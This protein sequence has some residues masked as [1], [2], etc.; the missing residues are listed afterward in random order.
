MKAIQ[1]NEISS[2]KPTRFSDTVTQYEAT[3]CDGLTDD[4]VKAAIG[5]RPKDS[6]KGFQ[7]VYDESFKRVDD[8]RA[9]W[10]T[11]SEYLD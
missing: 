4:E 2:Y 6:A 10:T 1:I 3:N 11:V 9:T 8:H 5:Y 7:P